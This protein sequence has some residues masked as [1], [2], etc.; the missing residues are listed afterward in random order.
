M[1]YQT[2]RDSFM[3]AMSAAG[4]PL[5]VAR[6]ML[7]YAAI[8]DRLAVA[9]CNGDWP[10]DNGT[11]GAECPTCGGI[12]RAGITRRGCLDCRTEAKLV[13]LLDPFGIRVETGG[14]PRGY[15]VKLH[16]PT[17]AHNTWGNGGADGY[18]VPVR[19]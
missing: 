15:T 12:W 19:S 11:G 3:A 9:Q 7:R 2:D 8:I 17:G 6:K 10:A 18:G 14:D 4:V 5:E 1:S 16:L 13:A